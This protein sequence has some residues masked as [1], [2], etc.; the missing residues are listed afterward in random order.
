MPA[1]ARSP[2]GGEHVFSRQ[3]QAAVVAVADKLL[4]H[5]D[6]LRHS[7]L[8]PIEGGK[9][10]VESWIAH[11]R[12]VQN[13]CDGLQQEY[14]S[15]GPTNLFVGF[16][17]MDEATPE[18]VRRL[19]EA[20]GWSQGRLADEARAIAQADKFPGA[21]TQQSL[22]QYEGGRAKRPPVWLRYVVE[23][24]SI[25]GQAIRSEVEPL[26]ISDPRNAK[27]GDEALPMIPLLGTAM[28]G[29]WNGPE[30]HIEL[31]E[32]DMHDVMGHVSRPQS[33]KN[34]D[35][36]YA[37][38]IVGDSMWPRF[39]PGR[40]VIVSPRSSVSIGDDVIVQLL[41]KEDAAGDR[42][43][44]QVL[45]KELV[46]RTASFIE[47]RQFNPDVTFKVGA[48]EIAAVHKVVGELF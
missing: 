10:T 27:Y 20:K 3:R 41:G 45:I 13:C 9:G 46:R 22:A 36:A 26:R 42:R 4:G 39:R 19:R 7:A 6:S 47:L 32:L 15:S 23:A 33:L 35:R 18:T 40:R 8:V 38:T 5:A 25:G 29:E 37:V 24:L 44:T 1:D 21:L 31:T 17:G 16:V 12:T 43:V 14:C 11:G 28:A 30:F 48:D 34:D 2:L